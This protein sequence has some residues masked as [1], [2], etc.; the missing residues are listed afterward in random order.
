MFYL[1]HDN[2]RN[3]AQICSHILH[4][5]YQTDNEILMMKSHIQY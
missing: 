5:T 2:D 1:L 3:T 4:I